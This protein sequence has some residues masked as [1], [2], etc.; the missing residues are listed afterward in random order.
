LYGAIAVYLGGVFLHKAWQL[1]QAPTDKQ[2]ARSLFKY[3]ILYMM[4][5]CTAMVID[6][7]PLTHN[8]IAAI[9]PV[10]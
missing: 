3:S 5:L 6:S 2:L 9:L 1:K 7:L 4:L 10:S 8:L